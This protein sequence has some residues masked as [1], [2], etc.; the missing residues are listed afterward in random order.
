MRTS[1]ATEPLLDLTPL[2]CTAEARWAGTFRIAP[3]VFA[4]YA[5]A[6]LA[7]GADAQ[8]HGEELYLACGCALGVPAAIAVFE[9]LLTNE[10]AAALR[11]LHLESAAADEVCQMAREKLLVGEP[12]RGPRIAEYAGRGTLSGWIRVVVTRIALNA[13][14]APRREVPLEEVLVNLEPVDTYDPA[15]SGLRDKVGDSLHSALDRAMRAISAE[16]RVLLRQRFVDGLTTVQ[17]AAL[18]R[19]HRSTMRRRLDAILRAIR[20]HTEELLEREVGCGHATAVSLV[21]IVISQ[22][23][24][25]IHRYLAPCE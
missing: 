11:H 15:L 14:R 24:L 8:V 6:R 18:Y 25:S 13:L 16:D 2:V 7:P 3:P 10:S 17:L 21:H 22:T 19:K 23:H 12:G 4:A 1:T 5:A 20:I 9:V